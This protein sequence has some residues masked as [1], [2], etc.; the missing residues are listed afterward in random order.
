MFCQ[1]IPYTP[2]SLPCGLGLCRAQAFWG[3]R[4]M[5]ALRL[6]LNP[7]TRKLKAVTGQVHLLG[8][9]GSAEPVMPDPKVVCRVLGT[10][11]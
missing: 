1:P 9:A 2:F 11:T 3:G 8:G 7:R 6:A 4:Y 10:C 5:G